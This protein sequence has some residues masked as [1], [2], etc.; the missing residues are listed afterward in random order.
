MRMQVDCR[1]TQGLGCWWLRL[2]RPRSSSA[3]YSLILVLARASGWRAWAWWVRITRVGCS[4]VDP[5][6]LVGSTC[7]GAL[8]IGD[9]SMAHVCLARTSHL[10]VDDLGP[11]LPW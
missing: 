3:C 10:V 8:S 6:C 2:I 1:L 5:T 7:D 4:G 9:A 11:D